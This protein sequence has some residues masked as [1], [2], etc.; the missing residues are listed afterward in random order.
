MS[1][2]RTWAR[3]VNRP[4]AKVI[5]IVIAALGSTALGPVSIFLVLGVLAKPHGYL[6]ILGPMGFGGLLGLTGTWLRLLLPARHFQESSRLRNATG[7][8]LACGC[9]TAAVWTLMLSVK[10]S[11]FPNVLLP[12][13]VLAT[14]IFLLGATLG[15]TQDTP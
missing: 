2:L 3:T 10:L 12:A 1:V 8:L 9:L 14:G 4:V 15:E 13:F 11:P 7:A 6:L 5:L